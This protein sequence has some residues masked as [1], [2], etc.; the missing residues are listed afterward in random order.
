VKR[1]AAERKKYHVLVELP[2]TEQPWLVLIEATSDADA[3][4]TVARS[5]EVY[6]AGGK[7]VKVTRA[8]TGRTR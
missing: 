3:R 7:V 6:V 1:R 5:R 8:R 4:C 2:D